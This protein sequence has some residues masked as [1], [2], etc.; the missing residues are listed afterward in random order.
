[1]TVAGVLQ[2][3]SLPGEPLAAPV[4]IRERILCIA[5]ELFSRRSVRE[6]GVNELI[7]TSGGFEVDLLSAFPVKVLLGSGSYG[8]PGRGLVR[9]IRC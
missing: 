8:P 1:M 9:G 6:V 3:V 5:Y 4:D 7:E 2:A